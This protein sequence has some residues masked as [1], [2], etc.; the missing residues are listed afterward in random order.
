M[1]AIE[2]FRVIRYVITDHCTNLTRWRYYPH[3]ESGEH[4]VRFLAWAMRPRRTR[5]KTRSA[6]RR[7]Y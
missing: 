5:K 1:Q 2:L 3:S 4:T 7:C 6:A